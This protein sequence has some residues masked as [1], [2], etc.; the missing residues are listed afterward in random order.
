[1]EKESRNWRL[2][3]GE[4]RVETEGVALYLLSEI[5]Y[6][7]DTDCIWP[8]TTACI[9]LYLFFWFLAHKRL[10][11]L[12][13]MLCSVNLPFF[14]F[15]VLFN[16]EHTLVCLVLF[17]TLSSRIELILYPLYIPLVSPTLVS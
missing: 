7:K 15:L 16:E 5:S 6:K 9:C 14:W 17:L 13:C 4:W 3:I 8:K 11:K 10:V 12:L 1:M 2:E